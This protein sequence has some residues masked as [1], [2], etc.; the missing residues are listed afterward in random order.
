MFM[1]ILAIAIAGGLAYLWLIRGFFS[2]LLHLIC[3]VAAG[4][5]A[6]AAWEPISMAIL[7]GSPTKGF[8]S[9][10]GGMAFGVGLIVPFALSLFVFRVAMDK[11]LPANA[12]ADKTWDII[13]AGIC[14]AGSGTITAGIVVM[15]IG[16]LWLPQD[17]WGSQRLRWDNSNGS[18]VSDKKLIFPADDIVAGLY[19]KLSLTTFAVDNKSALGTQYPNLADVPSSIRR[20]MQAGRGRNFLRPADVT[21]QQ[22]FTVGAD[23]NWTAF[24]GYNVQSGLRQR[25]FQVNQPLVDRT[26]ETLIKPGAYI[27]GYVV[28]FKEAARERKSGQVNMT[29][30]QARLVCINGE[31]ETVEVFPA[32]MISRAD[33]S[34]V[35][36]VRFP[37]TDEDGLGTVAGD[38]TPLMA[39]EFVVP[40]GHRPLS[41]FV[42]NVRMD[43]SARQP[44]QRF[45]TSGSRQAA[46]DNG[47]LM[48][49]GRTEINEER[50]ITVNLGEDLRSRGIT[51]GETVRG[52]VLQDGTTGGLKVNSERKITDGLQRFKPQ[53]MHR[54]TLDKALRVDKFAVSEGTDLVQIAVTPGRE[55]ITPAVDIGVP[56]ISETTRDA[57]VYLLDDQGNLYSCIGYVYEDQNVGEIRYT[58]DAPISGLSQLPKLPSRTQRGQ[59]ITL[60]FEVTKN[61][62]IVG[63]VVGNELMIRFV[64]AVEF[65]E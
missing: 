2:A 46:I 39:F 42:K 49:A 40:A 24:E 58:R 41:L 61:V 31:G 51:E 15:G 29:P 8:F 5:V 25:D 52:I 20:T 4:A 21:L 14:G 35:R 28:Q 16:M 47:S 64:P 22:V 44:D 65:R 1:S 34:D 53:D 19:G 3:V 43:V 9:F 37:M 62:D 17:F 10:L 11:L 63:F 23:E 54:S 18:L 59:N 50:A 6:F 56:P 33:L 26:G 60:L 32:A 57:P 48:R 36:W 30:A 55:N 45:A 12:Q 7:K 38:G 13:G 27:V